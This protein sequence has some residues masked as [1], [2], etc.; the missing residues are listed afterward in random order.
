[1]QFI[2][3]PN[4]SYF[5]KCAKVTQNT[6]RSNFNKITTAAATISRFVTVQYKNVTFEII[7]IHLSRLAKSKRCVVV[8]VLFTVL[9][10]PGGIDNFFLMLI[11]NEIY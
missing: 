10:S 9:S 7:K 3:K 1:L 11:E 8:V 6:I 5:Q 4:D 2:I